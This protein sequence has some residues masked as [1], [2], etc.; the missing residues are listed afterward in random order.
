MFVFVGCR[1]GIEPEARR[2]LGM[3]LT[4]ACNLSSQHCI[5]GSLIA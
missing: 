2:L 4:A 1:L 3:L 5:I